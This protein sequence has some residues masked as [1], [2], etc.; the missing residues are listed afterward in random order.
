[1]Q[2]TTALGDL[3]FDDGTG[4]NV[5]AG[6]EWDDFGQE[7]TVGPDGFTS[8]LTAIQSKA[9][10]LKE[11]GHEKLRYGGRVEKVE[12]LEVKLQAQ[13][14]SKAKVWMEAINQAREHREATGVY[15][16]GSMNEDGIVGGGWYVEGGKRLGG[17]TLG[18]LA[19]VWD[20]EVCGVRGALEDTPSDSN[21]LILLDS[22]AAIAAVKKAG[23]T[24][25]ART[26]DLKWVMEGI[27][28]RKSRLGPNAVLFGWVKAHNKLHCN[29]EADRLAKEATNLYPEDPQITEGGLKQAWRKMREKERRVKRA[30][31]GRVVRWNRKAR[32]TYIQCRTRKG[33]LQAWRH[34]IGKT[35]DPE[36]R[37]CGR[38]AETGRHIA[39][40]C[41]HGEDIGWRW[42]TWED[43]DDRARWAKKEK[44]EKGFYTVD[45]VETFFS[46]ID[47]V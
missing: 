7:Y 21:V 39:L 38:Y 26:C 5:E 35:E 23:R 43:M 22:Q 4:R 20:G 16:D 40:L 31:M 10:V 2:D 15:T 11:E 12:V 3:I 28:E 32:V 45:L 27:R 44:D 42:S 37:K 1:M 9:G 25:K 41:T 17:A 30:G 24:G 29:E 46:K 14:D 34:K 36:C 13:A 47:L 33:N 8:V 19:T 18:R 6:R